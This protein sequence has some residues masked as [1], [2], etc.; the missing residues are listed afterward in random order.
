M[1]FTAVN[2]WAGLKRVKSNVFLGIHCGALYSEKLQIRP[3]GDMKEGLKTTSQYPRW[4]DGSVKAS[5][6]HNFICF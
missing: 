2:L 1:I 4:A 6:R 3:G 5:S